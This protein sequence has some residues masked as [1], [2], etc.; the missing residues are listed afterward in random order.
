LFSLRLRE[1]GMIKSS[2]SK[3]ISESTNWSYL[4][5]LNRELK[6]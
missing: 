4:N 5:E 3:I 6:A 2:P 1:V